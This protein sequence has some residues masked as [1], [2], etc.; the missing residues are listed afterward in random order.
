MV[1]LKNIHVD[2][3][4]KGDIDDDDDNGD[5]NNNNIKMSSGYQPVIAFCTFVS[6]LPIFVQYIQFIYPESIYYFLNKGRFTEAVN[7]LISKH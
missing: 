5:E 3:L 2:T 6:E 7:S 1:C 4:H